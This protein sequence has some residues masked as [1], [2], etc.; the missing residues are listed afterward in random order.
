[1]KERERERERERE[2]KKLIRL[3]DP[4]YSILFSLWSEKEDAQK[5]MMKGRRHTKNQRTE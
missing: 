1:M 2:I 4:I 3:S 5:K